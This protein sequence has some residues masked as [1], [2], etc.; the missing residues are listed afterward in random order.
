[1]IELLDDGLV[2]FYEAGDF[3]ESFMRPVAE[4]DGLDRD[5]VVSALAE[6]S[7]SEPDGRI[8]APWL[9]LLATEKGRAYSSRTRLERPP[10]ASPQP[11]REPDPRI[12]AA[13]DLLKRDTSDAAALDLLEEALADAQATRC[14]SA[15]PSR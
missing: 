5:E 4:S 2:Y 13:V 1:M 7:R 11:L 9:L 8:R 6:G 3:G 15:P 12:E 14:R 10:V